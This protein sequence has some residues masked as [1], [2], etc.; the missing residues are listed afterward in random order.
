MNIPTQRSSHLETAIV[1]ALTFASLALLGLV[2]AYWT[3]TWISPRI[4]PRVQPSVEAGGPAESAAGLFGRV[5]SAAGAAPTGM[6]I[7]LLGV[8]AA[9]DG[10]HGYAV[11]QLDPKDIRAVRYGDN[12]APGIRLAEIHVDHVILE[13]NG[14]RESLAWPAKAKEP[15]PVN[16]TS[17]AQAAAAAAAMRGGK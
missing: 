6:A 12:I 17:A 7:K 11:V 13:R 9:P 15:A 8:A 3:W 1:S 2:L 4:E 16:A 14:V 5:R 10:R